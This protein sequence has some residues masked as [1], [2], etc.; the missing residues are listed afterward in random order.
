MQTPSASAIQ[1]SKNIGQQLSVIAAD[2][3]H[4]IAVA[5]PNKRVNQGRRCYDELTFQQLN[6]DS[7]RIAAALQS[8][9]LQPAQRIVLMVRPGLDFISL[10]FALF[11]AAATVVLIDPGMGRNHL[12]QCL[13]DAEPDGFVGISIAQA[14]RILY[15]RN[16]PNARLNVTVGRRWCWGGPTLKQL[17]LHSAEEFQ[18]PAVNADDPAAIIF[19]TGSTGP[20][21]GVLYR[22][23]NFSQQVQQ[24]RDMYEIQPGEIDLPGFP[25][26][27]LFNS[28]MG[29]TTVIPDMDPTRPAEVNPANIIEPIQDWKITQAFGSPALWNAVGK[30]CE[31]N[32]IKLPTLRRVL[33]AGAPVPNHVLQKLKGAIAVDGDIHT[34]YGATEALPV[35]TISG[36]EVLES[37]A[38][39]TAVGAGTCVGR[40]FSKI[41]WKVIRIHDDPI[42]A[43]DEVEELPQGEIGELIVQGPVVTTEYVT[44]TESNLLAK[45]NDETIWH[46]MGDVGYLDELDRF[47]F[48]GRKAHRL[49]T[50][51]G[52][53]F[54]IRCEAIFNQHPAIYRS[55]LVGLGQAPRQH[56][57]LI[58]EPWPDQLSNDE[59][60]QQQLRQE[61]HE[62][63]QKNEL[64]SNIRLDHI[65]LRAALPVD[66][67][68]NAKIFREQL[69][70]WAAKE[71]DA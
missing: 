71:L 36:T 69:S 59:S 70:V 63:G 62:L 44:R 50:E 37:T 10:T 51:R 26:F 23:G 21:K 34:P 2:R 43:I 12:I 19:T 46:R 55:A 16:F 57:V 42:Q 48:C 52:T 49:V 29:V 27:A 41:K 33:S 58:A 35:A 6:E 47:W 60:A 14:A 32:D 28:V 1:L 45:I 31:A 13:S 24:L 7:D 67:R 61:L 4:Q 66:I 18:P 3:P 54:T 38:E 22:H 64:T 17:R 15:R 30:H 8:L 56:P 53:M 39:Q 40:R 5:A 11:K 25:L 65:L 9:G 68:H 20:P